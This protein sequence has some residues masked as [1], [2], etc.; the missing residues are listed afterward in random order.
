M[1]LKR[2]L[3]MKLSLPSS[4]SSDGML[5]GLLLE[6][7]EYT[8]WFSQYS[9]AA[10]V[11][12]NFASPQPELSPVAAELIRS[13]AKDSTL[14]QQSLDQLITELEQIKNT[15]PVMTIT[16]A[17]P[18]TAEV[19]QS[20]VTWCRANI[21]ANILVN[22]R[23]NSTLLGG[24]VVRFGSHIHD[25]SFRRVILGERHRWSEILGRV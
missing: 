9:V 10:R 19:K 1:N 5:T 7:R 23:F 12:A 4:I 2:Q 15:A 13:W 17:A 14:S 18:A 22:F 6:V 21:D 16:L 20:L 8:K 24:M 3:A 25:W 11:K